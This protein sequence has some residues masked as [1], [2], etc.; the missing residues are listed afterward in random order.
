MAVAGGH[1][2]VT[3]ILMEKGAVPTKEH[4]RQSVTPSLASALER[5]VMWKPSE[6]CEAC[7]NCGR[8][9]TLTRR[10]HHCR[11]CGNVFCGTCCPQVKSEGAVRRCQDC[12]KDCLEKSLSSTQ[13]LEQLYNK[14]EDD[15]ASTIDSL[16]RTPS[17]APR[18][19]LT[20]VRVLSIINNK[21]ST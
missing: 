18:S 11:T 14:M 16:E 3:Q 17:T 8:G 1:L 12:V 6:S 5:K 4:V 20:R 2:K 10:K 13:G 15:K 9:F 21:R 19:N 7:A